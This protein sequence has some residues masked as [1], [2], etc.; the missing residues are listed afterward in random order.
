MADFGG[1]VLTI[2][3]DQPVFQRE[4]GL[5]YPLTR[6]SLFTLVNDMNK[7]RI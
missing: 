2:R 5:F 1:F 4:F 3:S 6:F 7:C